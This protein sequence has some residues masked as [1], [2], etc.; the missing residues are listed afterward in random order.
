MSSHT[1][2]A[3]FWGES[4]CTRKPLGVTGVSG[5]SAAGVSAAGGNPQ[6]FQIVPSVT[7]ALAGGAGHS[8]DVE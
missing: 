3:L 1:S 8:L 4:V 2:E 7:C 6:A 5:D